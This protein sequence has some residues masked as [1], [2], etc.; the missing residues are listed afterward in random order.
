MVVA[1][2]LAL[3]AW[4]VALLGVCAAVENLGPGLGLGL[5]DT[6]AGQG[7]AVFASA[8][9]R[10]R[11][12]VGLFV[13]L[14]VAAAVLVG[15]LAAPLLQTVFGPRDAAGKPSTPVLAA[16]SGED[17]EPAAA[18]PHPNGRVSDPRRRAPAPA[19]VDA[20]PRSRGRGGGRAAGGRKSAAA[21]AVAVLGVG[22]VA[23][24]ALP[25]AWAVRFALSS[26]QRVALLCYWAALLAAALPAM[27]WLS[28]ARRVPTIIVRKV[29]PLCVLFRVKTGSSSAHCRLQQQLTSRAARL[30]RG[31]LSRM[32]RA[33]PASPLILLVSLA[34]DCVCPAAWRVPRRLGL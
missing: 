4:D 17:A 22:A 23:A 32:W 6:A 2:A 21:L 10:E 9:L 12:P 14:L 3:L 31:R 25:A 18:A 19:A 28:R 34:L 15:T 5:G 26:P 30:A 33:L 20:H 13:E 16:H 7:M 8:V 24:A 1:Q 27:D 29:P 11:S